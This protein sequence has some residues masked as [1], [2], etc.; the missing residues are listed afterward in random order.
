MLLLEVFKD[1]AV[2][3]LIGGKHSFYP[4]LV[5]LPERIVYENTV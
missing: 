5:K 4:P 3:R 1:R 2:V